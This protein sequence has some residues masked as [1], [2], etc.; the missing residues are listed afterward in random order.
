MVWKGGA[1]CLCRFSKNGLNGGDDTNIVLLQNTDTTLVIM[2]S[3]DRL[4]GLTF[5]GRGRRSTGLGLVEGACGTILL[6]DIADRRL[7]ISFPSSALRL[8]TSREWN[9]FWV[10][11]R[12]LQ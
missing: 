8:G 11:H 3:I 5:R 1:S 4:G 12:E 9:A 10:S 6:V 2:I 7:S